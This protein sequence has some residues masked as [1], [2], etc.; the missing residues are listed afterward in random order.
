MTVGF[1]ADT[2]NSLSLSATHTKSHARVGPRKHHSA[3]LSLI[4]LLTCLFNPPN[5]ELRGLHIFEY[6]CVCSCRHS[7]TVYTQDITQCS[8]INQYQVF[9]HLHTQKQPHSC[10]DIHADKHYQTSF[11]VFIS[12]SFPCR[13]WIE[14]TLH[15]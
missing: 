8:N 1:D 15:A 10:V 3:F 4:L 12:F 2:Q 14:S 9:P 13:R 7:Y 6:V 5:T 11:T